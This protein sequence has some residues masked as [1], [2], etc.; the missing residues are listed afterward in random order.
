M[1]KQSEVSNQPSALENNKIHQAI[2]WSLKMFSLIDS[3]YLQGPD[4]TEFDFNTGKAVEDA[5][6][7]LNAAAAEIAR[8][9]LIAAA[10]E[11]AVLHCIGTGTG[12]YTVKAELMNELAALLK[13][14]E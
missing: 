13:E 8:L 9:Q 3:H 5:V 10:A 12:N 2:E 4:V 6:D 7:M 11:K 14:S 1:E